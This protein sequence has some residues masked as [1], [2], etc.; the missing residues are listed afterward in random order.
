M[1]N[2]K[3]LAARADEA[4]IPLRTLA[5]DYLLARNGRGQVLGGQHLSDPNSFKGDKG[6]ERA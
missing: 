5:G 6:Y 4:G 2:G 1:N 3:I